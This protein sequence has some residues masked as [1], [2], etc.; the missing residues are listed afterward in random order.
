[1]LHGKIQNRLHGHLGRITVKAHRRVASSAVSL[2]PALQ[3]R[4]L[5]T[6]DCY[7]APH[8]SSDAAKYKVRGSNQAQSSP[9]IVQLD[10][11]FHYQYREG[12]KNQEGH[13][14]LKNLKL[15]KSKFG[16]AD[17]IRGNMHGVFEECDTPTYQRRNIPRFVVKRFEVQIPGGQHETVGDH[18]EE[19]GA[20]KNGHGYG[21][22]AEL[23][24]LIY[25]SPQAV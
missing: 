15:G 5:G 9:N 6:A 25:V 19:D 11:M 21:T 1:M 8:I 20:G 13:T 17:T 23:R 4:E 10:W 12:N 16:V 18:E 22:I 2:P 14:H 3:R 7:T 24:R